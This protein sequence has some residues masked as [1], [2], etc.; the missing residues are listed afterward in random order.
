MKK[1]ADIWKSIRGHHLRGQIAFAVGLAALSFF[2]VAVYAAATVVLGVGTLEDSETFDGPT[3]VT[4]R[5]ISF[6]P[7]EVGAWHY[8]PGPLFNVVTQGTVTV[9]DGCGGERSFSAGQ[10][11]EEGG[12]VHRPKNLGDEATFAY[13]TFLIPQGNP[14]TVN[15]PGN[16]RA[17]GPP[18]NYDE[19]RRGGWQDF[20]HPQTFENQGQCMLFVLR[21]KLSRFEN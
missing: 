11:F 12:R 16:E 8:H 14:T 6:A 3:T 17:C 20:N 7:D 18:R 10:A 5:T 19:C 2:A 1:A 9:E 15:I 4:A 21:N 13:Q